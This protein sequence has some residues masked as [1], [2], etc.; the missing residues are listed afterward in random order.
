MTDRNRDDQTESEHETKGD[1]AQTETTPSKAR[2]PEE[3]ADHIM[4]RWRGL[5]ACALFTGCSTELPLSDRHACPGD[6][7]D[8]GSVTPD[9]AV[10]DVGTPPASSCPPII[11]GTVTWPSG[12]A[13]VIIGADASSG[14]GPLVQYWHGTFQTPELVIAQD[15]GVAALRDVVLREG[16]VLVLPR[17]DPAAV[18]RPDT[19]FPWWS[20]C[21]SAMVS[22]DVQDDFAFASEI[23]ACVLEQ[24]LAAPD[25]VSST[26]LSAGGI[27]SS[28]LATRVD[29]LAGIVSWSGG[30][31]YGGDWVP[32]STGVS[33]LAL[34][35]GPN[36]VYCGA[37]S[38]G[39]YSFVEPTES[40]A[41]DAAAA[42]VQTILCDHASGHS[43]AMGM[44][45]A[46]FTAAV[47]RGAPYAGP[48]F[49]PWGA[50][51]LANYCYT[52][53]DESPWE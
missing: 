35:G 18:A 23:V 44:Q 41:I 30:M 20:V 39:C 24:G 51:M 36:D 46:E 42:G 22:C 16:G 29:W 13:A 52:P 48:P 31:P 19:P 1:D 47:R 2:S 10:P 5:F 50:W 43:G 45:G 49:G 26:G 7:P 8:V 12:R 27:F 53:G 15:S 32:V 40:L 21:G 3:R 9:L 6:I 4:R 17:A 34:H 25:R 14:T 28:Q 33:V 38:G 37:G 11:D